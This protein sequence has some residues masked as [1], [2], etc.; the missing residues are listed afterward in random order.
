MVAEVGEKISKK[1]D[2]NMEGFG[3]GEDMRS[4]PRYL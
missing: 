1:V 3:A 2:V 4:L